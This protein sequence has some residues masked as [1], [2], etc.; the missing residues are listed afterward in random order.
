MFFTLLITYTYCTGGLFQK[1]KTF[2][3]V[4]SKFSKQINSQTGGVLQERPVVTQ[5]R[6]CRAHFGAGLHN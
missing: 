3:Y 6:L 4:D 1:K 2:Y 5:S